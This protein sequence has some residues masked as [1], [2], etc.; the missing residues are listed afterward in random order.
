[1]ETQKRLYRSEKNKV[2]AGVLGGIGEYAGID[3]V[4]IRVLYVVLTAFTGLAPAIIAY[5]ITLF[6]VPR[7]VHTAFV[8]EAHER[9]EV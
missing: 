5:L 9:E 7:R 8:P 3:P 1:M 2:F 4:L 6:V